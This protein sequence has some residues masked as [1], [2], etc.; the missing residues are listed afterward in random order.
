MMDD[1]SPA[2]NLGQ[3]RE[4]YGMEYSCDLFTLIDKTNYMNATRA[5]DRF[6]IL[7]GLANDAVNKAFDPDYD[8]P[9][10]ITVCRYAAM[11][12]ER[13]KAIELLARAGLDL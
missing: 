4:T 6:F 11:F 3:L 9:L 2:L 13:G 12:V 8:S 1:V 7:L 5:R 10:E